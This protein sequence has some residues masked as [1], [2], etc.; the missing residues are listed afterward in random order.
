M[1]V[2]TF[3]RWEND[4]QTIGPQADALI[5]YVYFRVVEQEGQ[6]LAGPIA[7]EIAAAT[8]TRR[9]SSVVLVDAGNPS[10]YSYDC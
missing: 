8:Q 3:S 9:A 10:I 2:S 6:D 4:A 1:D 7:K 5:R